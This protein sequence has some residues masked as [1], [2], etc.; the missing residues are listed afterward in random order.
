MR[1]STSMTANEL[2]AAVN[3]YRINYYHKDSSRAEQVGANVI[4]FPNGAVLIAWD[5][6]LNAG[7]KAITVADGTAVGY[8]FEYEG[9]TIYEY[10]P[11]DCIVIE[12]WEINY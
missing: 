6:A 3:F 4:G 7:D 2:L 8:V 1:S 5:N 9:E 12:R 11:E 10:A